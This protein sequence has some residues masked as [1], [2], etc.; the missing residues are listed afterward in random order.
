[1]RQTL[2]LDQAVLHYARASALD[3]THKM[4]LYSWAK[5]LDSSDKPDEAWEK[6]ERGADQKMWPSAVQCCVDTTPGLRAKP[7]W[8]VSEI[9]AVSAAGIRT[10]QENWQALAAEAAELYARRKFGL[11]YGND[12]PQPVYLFVCDF[13]PR[14]WMMTWK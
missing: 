6:W 12:H 11:N 14:Q 3:P 5:A 7:F 8:N 2:R 1:M 4:A 13:K 9:D 10:L